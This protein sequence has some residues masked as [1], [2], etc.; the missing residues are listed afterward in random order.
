MISEAPLYTSG[1]SKFSVCPQ[2]SAMGKEEVMKKFALWIP[3]ALAALTISP[4]AHADKY[5]KEKCEP[6]LQKEK[7]KFERC[8]DTRCRDTSL[9]Y[10]TFDQQKRN[11]CMASG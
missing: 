8:V 6:I 4:A 10:G 9:R 11:S 2:L 1:A 3:L 5:D 7:A